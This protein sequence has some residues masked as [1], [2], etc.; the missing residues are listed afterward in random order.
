M[1]TCVLKFKELNI[2]VRYLDKIYLI[3]QGM[4]MAHL[5]CA[6]YHVR[7]QKIV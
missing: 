1:E 6:I 5:E 7:H 2:N 4:F 3:I